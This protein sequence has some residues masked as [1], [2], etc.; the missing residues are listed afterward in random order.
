MSSKLNLPVVSWA[1]VTAVPVSTPRAKTRNI[2][3]SGAGGLGFTL[4]GMMQAMEDAGE[5]DELQNVGGTSAG[6]MMALLVGLGYRGEDFEQLA[7]TQ[8]FEK[9]TDFDWRESLRVPRNLIKGGVFSGKELEEYCAYAI[10]KR[11]GQPEMSFAQLHAH[12]ERAKAG[13]INYFNQLYA[14]SLQRLEG[15]HKRFGQYEENF[16]FDFA[17]GREMMQRAVA[18]KDLY[19][20]A[21]EQVGNYKTHKNP[22]R[23]VCF[24]HQNKDFSDISIAKGVLASAAFPYVFCKQTL[25]G[26]VFRDGGLTNNYPLEIF[27]EPDGTPNP[28]TFCLGVDI[29]KP[30]IATGQT[31]PESKKM[32]QFEKLAGL[33]WPQFRQTKAIFDAHKTAEFEDN[34][35]TPRT[36]LTPVSGDVVDFNLSRDQRAGY[37]KQGYEKVTENL[38]EEKPIQPENANEKTRK[39]SFVEREQQNSITPAYRR[40]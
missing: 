26:R 11:T 13:D 36:W 23:E 22:Y 25:K 16:R 24:S 10:A 40:A 18:M 35:D 6:A 31:P 21:S 15:M 37:F 30:S 29:V 14:Q 9:F 33:L 34:R 32:K 5:L 4:L 8:D 19:V 28:H 38:A 3:F 12:I 27:D 1:M 7:M 20:V 17:S 39:K 2:V